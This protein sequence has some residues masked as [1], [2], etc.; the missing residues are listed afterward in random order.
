MALLPDDTRDGRIGWRRRMCDYGHGRNLRGL[1]AIHR[2]DRESTS[3]RFGHGHNYNHGSPPGNDAGCTWAPTSGVD[4]AGADDPGCRNVRSRPQLAT[5]G[6]RVGAREALRG[7]Q[8][9]R[10][11]PARSGGRRRNRVRGTAGVVPDV[12]L[13]AVGTTWPSCRSRH[14]AALGTVPRRGR[15]RLHQLS[16][17]PGT[18]RTH[19]CPAWSLGSPTP[20]HRRIPA[21]S[22]ASP[23]AALERGPTCRDIRWSRRHG[24]GHVRCASAR[25]GTPHERVS[26]KVEPGQ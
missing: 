2:C 1:D 24:R 4:H 25:Y 7:R 22:S 9:R 21:P 14:S 17:V 18:T 5:R 20:V 23:V 19:R 8:D 12:A 3:G 26:N 16:G 6:R 11:R 10:C 15:L 13:T